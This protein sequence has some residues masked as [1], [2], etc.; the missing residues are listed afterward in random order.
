MVYIV[1]LND[2]FL[3][4]SNYGLVSGYTVSPRFLLSVFLYSPRPVIIYF[5]GTNIN[6]PFPVQY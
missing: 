1:S 3:S 2:Y 5:S 4:I 6:I